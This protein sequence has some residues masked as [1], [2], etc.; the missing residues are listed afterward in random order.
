MFRGSVKGTG[1]PLNSPV[2]FSLHLSCIAV[3]HHISI[4]FC[5]ENPGKYSKTARTVCSNHVT[6]IQSRSIRW[7]NISS[8]FL[9][10]IV[11]LKKTIRVNCS[12]CAFMTLVI[13]HAKRMRPFILSFVACLPNTIFLH[14]IS[15][16]TRFLKKKKIFVEHKICVVI[17]SSI[18]SEII[19][20]SKNNCLR[21][22]HT[23]T[24]VFM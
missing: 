2:S 5:S 15:Q 4:G 21:Y 23:Y 1:Y 20:H 8:G 17:F 18:L 22:Y 16:T 11:A 6:K 9:E 3:Y 13:Q 12:E 19:D 10:N 14:V 7:I 24:Y